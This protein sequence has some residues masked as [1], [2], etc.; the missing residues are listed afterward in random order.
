MNWI[1]FRTIKA[2]VSIAA[3]LEHYHWKSVRRRGK[4]HLEGC[5][6][7]HGGQRPDA[8]H[9]D[10]RKNAFHCFSCQAGG[11]VLD[12]V[13]AIEGCSIRQA[14]LWLQQWCGVRTAAQSGV[15]IFAEGKGQRV[16]EKE[17]ITRP[18][19]FA[20]HPIDSAH[21]YL[22]QR[23]IAPET[24]TQFG[25]GYYP[26]PGWM[27][28]RVV[29]PIHDE[30]GQL[31]AYAGRSVDGTAAK[32]K[33]PGGFHKSRV[34]FN[35]HRATASGQD[36]VV[37]VEGFFDC[38]KVHQAGQASVVALM[39]CCLS[40]EQQTLL[41]RRFSKIILMLDADAAG[42]RGTFTIADRLSC[43][44]E[45]VALPIGHQPDQ[46][47]SEEIRRALSGAVR[48]ERTTSKE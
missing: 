22:S 40:Q 39:G 31:L 48:R 5:C 3:V 26:G 23:G 24:A 37:V 43:H 45:I 20:L 7:I 28:G 8:F 19:T 2:G 44:L 10:V 27:H 15:N 32:Y 13:A 46:L 4:D 6:P 33:L 1:D 47:S 25:V 14:G 35:L 29:I 17:M 42:R 11:S 38:M 36:R 41:L 18:L 30:S 21:P 16:R 34:L 9:V 12:L